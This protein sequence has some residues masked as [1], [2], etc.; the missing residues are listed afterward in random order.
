VRSLSEFMHPDLSMYIYGDDKKFLHFRYFKIIDFQEYMTVSAE[1]E[2]YKDV[3][4]V[5]GQD[6]HLA[7]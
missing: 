7:R 1:K 5:F 2:G 3:V 6:I 4:L